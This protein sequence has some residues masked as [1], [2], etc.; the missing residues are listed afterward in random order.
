MTDNADT[1]ASEIERAAESD[2]AGDIADAIVATLSRGDWREGLAQLND[3]WMEAWFYIPPE[4]MRSLLGGIPAEAIA[5][6]PGTQYLLSLVSGSPRPATPEEAEA[7]TPRTAVLLE[8]MQVADLRFSGRLRDAL[9]GTRALMD[10]HHHPGS[11]LVDSSA[12]LE[13]LVFLQAGATALLAGD[14][15]TAAAWLTRAR[16]DTASS[17]RF[18]NRDAAAKLAVLHALAGS[19]SE[20]RA[21]LH[22]AMTGARSR[23]W[24][25][26]WID[27]TAQ[28]ARVLIETDDR[29]QAAELARLPWRVHGEM[30][31]FAIAAQVRALLCAGDLH[32]AQHALTTAAAM[33]IPGADGD[34]IVGAVI[35]VGLATVA[36]ARGN[37]SDARAH[38][39]RAPEDTVFART[40]A[41][42]AE[43]MAGRPAEAARLGTLTLAEFS[44]FAQI[45][46]ELTGIIATAELH[47]GDTDGARRKAL[48][49]TRR[50][51]EVPPGAH[52]RLPVEL[53]TH[54]RQQ[55]HDDP[56][57]AL[58]ST[59]EIPALF[60]ATQHFVDLSERELEV[61]RLLATPATRRELCDQ[62]FIS[63]NTLASHIKN[64]YRK[65]A[66]TSRE[67]AVQ[68]A[69]IRGLL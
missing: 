19:V 55:W 43:L 3:H 66:V 67:E 25:E 31:P 63:A 33:G 68:Q 52:A 10:R 69:G 35:P 16:D 6:H 50:W 38:L 64:V 44:G 27:S 22:E 18:V 28:M 13:P 9:A 51:H 49:L 24:T 42:R 41:A 21:Y 20:A 32:A 46:F 15:D 1:E 57:L 61:L 2:A 26:H 4:S 8:A 39:D 17:M 56:D 65:L 14:L 11:A 45:A 36:L 7:I 12:G 37:A 34:G 5:E 30:W 53:L 59:S 40:L 54:A 23:A 47:L 48:E 62:L 58:L 60:P 29:D